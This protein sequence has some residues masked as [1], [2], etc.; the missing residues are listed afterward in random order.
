MGGESQSKGQ[1]SKG[2]DK[3]AGAHQ[4]SSD[5]TAGSTAKSQNKITGSTAKGDNKGANKLAK[6]PQSQRK[7]SSSSSFCACIIMIYAIVAMFVLKT[8]AEHP[9]LFAMTASDVRLKKNIDISHYGMNEVLQLEPKSYHYINQDNEGTRHIGLMV[10]D[11]AKIMPE[12][13]VPLSQRQS[14]EFLTSDETMYGL[15]YQELIPVLINAI[16][17]LKSQVDNLKM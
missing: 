15:K 12:L 11:V 1:S 5:K 10:Q 17:E 13:V 9:E 6:G 16:K 2:G 3:N 4:K 14:A 7:I 8:G